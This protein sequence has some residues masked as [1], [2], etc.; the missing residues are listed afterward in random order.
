MAGSVDLKTVSEGFNDEARD[1]APNVA[2]W[3]VG[4]DGCKGTQAA[5][6][7]LFPNVLNLLCFL[8]GVA[9]EARSSD[10]CRITSR[11][12]AF[13]EDTFATVPRRR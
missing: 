11:T 6:K 10:L 5:W 2:P 3:T 4:I 8:Q 12:S 1:I 9:K 13:L 7:L